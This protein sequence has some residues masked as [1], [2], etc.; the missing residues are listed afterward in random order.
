MA[1]IDVL[2]LTPDFPP[3]PGGIQVVAHRLAA[4]ASRLST[5]VV[6][7]D[8]AGAAAFDQAQP[9][10][11]RRVAATRLPHRPRI[12]LLNLRGLREGLSSRPGAILS[13]HIVTSPAAR[14]IARAR[15]VPVVQY[16][17]ADEIRARPRLARQAV[18]AD[19][20]VALSRH[21]ERLAL[22]AG[23]EPSRLHVIPC[24]VD[25]PP[26]PSAERQGEPWVV[27]VA[28]LT[29]PYKG[30]D[31][32]ISALPSIRRRVPGVRWAVVGDGPLRAE[33]ER[34][35][36]DAGVAEAVTFTG[37]VTDSERDR[38]LERAHVF[39]MPSRLPPGGAGGEGFGIVYL[40]AAAHGLPVVAG[41]VGGA[42]DAV[43]DGRTGL[44]VDPTDHEA[45]AD[46]VADLLLDRER[47]KTLGR[48]GMDRAQDFA[49]PEIARRVEDVVLG[50]AS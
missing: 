21:T 41:D 28:R 15:S 36:E 45:V 9:F 16:L 46:A 18:R 20:V 13:M 29:Q 22:A 50:V 33:L 10:S 42:P 7:L 27:T 40:E 31:V 24:G 3:A 6:T 49:W 43:E 1:D 39:A 26:N 25:L 30:H 19:A 2:M 47:A 8:G 11:V 32:M 23:A 44:L 37:V 34:A 38:W 12:A 48:A 4:H 17:Y 14:A 35:A 5:R